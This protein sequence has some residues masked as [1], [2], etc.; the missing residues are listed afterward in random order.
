MGRAGFI[1]THRLHVLG[2]RGDVHVPPSCLFSRAVNKI[3]LR[4]RMDAGL[5][6]SVLMKRISCIFIVLLPLWVPQIS[7]V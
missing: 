2:G 3:R 4:R 7:W 5:F 6:V 1:R